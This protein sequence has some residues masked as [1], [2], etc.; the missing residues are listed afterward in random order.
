MGDSLAI[1]IKEPPIK[2]KNTENPVSWRVIIAP[3]N[4]L[5]KAEIITLKDSDIRKFISRR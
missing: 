4:R 3:R 2:P 5:G 1:P